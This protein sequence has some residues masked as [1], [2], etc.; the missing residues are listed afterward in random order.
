[1]VVST[2]TPD[3]LRTGNAKIKKIEKKISGNGLT[4]I[5][6]KIGKHRETSAQN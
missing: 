4:L 5:R 3:T 1:M 6:F 2:I